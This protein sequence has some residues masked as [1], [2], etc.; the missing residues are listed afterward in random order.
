MARLRLP[1]LCLLLCLAALPAQASAAS[2]FVIRGA[3]FG[4]GVGMSQYGAYGFALHGVG[5]RDILAHYYTGTTVGTVDTG[6]EVRVLLQS[7]RGNA[8][9]TGATLAGDRR[10]DPARTY[11]AR[12]RGDVVDLPVGARAPAGDVRR[13][14]ARQRPEPADA[15][16]PRRQRPR[17]RHLP[18]GARVPTGPLRRRQR[19]QRRGARRLRAGRR[20]RG[21][22]RLVAA[23]RAEGPGRRRA[24]VRDHDLEGRRGLGSVSGHALPGLRAASPASGRRAT[25][26]SPRPAAR[27]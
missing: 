18:R 19:G 27:S 20:P 12:G 25:S 7:P 9:F 4:H 21:V 11:Q 22:A 10:L 2:R 23:R 1:F 17:E 14:A 3:G 15:A 16:R 26:R 13:A 6:R 5:Y 8:S 24:H